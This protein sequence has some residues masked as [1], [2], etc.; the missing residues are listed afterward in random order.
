MATLTKGDIAFTSFNAE[1]DGF[2]LV[3]F[4]DIDPS[5]TI[6]FTDN[7][8][9]TP[10]SFNT[11]ES[12]SQWVSPT[13]TVAAGTVIRFSNIDATTLAA[14]VGAYTRATVASS[15]NY[16]IS[17]AADAMYAF[18]GTSAA[19][20]TTILT[21][22]SSGELG[23]IAGAT[24]STVLTNAGLTVGT[25]AVLLRASADYGEYGATTAF[26]A[27]NVTS[28]PVNAPRTGLSTFAAYKPLVFD[29]NNW[30][31]DQNDGTYASGVAPNIVGV[32]PNTT[33]FT[34]G[35]A[36]TASVRN[37]FN[38][39]GKSDILWRN[40]NGVIASWQMDGTAAPNPVHFG[41]APTDWKIAGTGDFNGDGKSDI[42]WRQDG[43]TIA[44]WNQGTTL[45]PTTTP[46]GVASAD[47]KVAGTG[48]FDGDGKS[49]ILWRQ[50]AGTVGVWKG[51]TTINSTTLSVGAAPTDWKIAGTGDFNGDG[52]AD[53]LWR[54][55][56]GTVALW[57]GGTTIDTNTVNIGA[58]PIDW[59]IAGTGDFNNDGKTDVLWR[60]DGGTVAISQM[61]SAGT[62][63]NAA[64]HVGANSTDWKIAGT[65]DYNSDSKSDI[66]WRNDLGTTAVWQMDGT[67]MIGSSVHIGIAPG[68]TPDWKIV[69][70]IA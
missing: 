61:N 49:D 7:E 4:V 3:T 39:D 57:K 54:N 13:T 24:T 58:A 45:N 48:D 19:A 20:P 22:I 67:S 41:A 53:I 34:I 30:S 2:S 46:V 42:L 8:A 17:T 28:T 40:D 25:D 69:A 15:T 43:G 31:V 56:N 51:G 29:A 65:I 38:G 9:L 64:V 68:A 44:V 16:G 55:D 47:W 52:K 5:T 35:A 63:L 50:D 14:S 59:K 21:A 60:H 36:P 27:T 66:L 1:E 18:L 26:N 32:A 11:G 6:Y 23:G 37:D 62:S 33:A 70:P 10:T 12:Y